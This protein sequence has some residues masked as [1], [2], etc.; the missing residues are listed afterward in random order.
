MRLPRRG[1]GPWVGMVPDVTV[2]GRPGTDLTEHHRRQQDS[3]AEALKL[4][5]LAPPARS[6]VEVA[7]IPK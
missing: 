2:P 1:G 4:S 6:A 5:W 7:E 3:A